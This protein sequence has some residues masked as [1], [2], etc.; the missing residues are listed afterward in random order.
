MIMHPKN[1]RLGIIFIDEQ[2]EGIKN[3]ICFLTKKRLV[4]LVFMGFLSKNM[5]ESAQGKRVDL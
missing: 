2:K 3:G 1:I 5:I 4:K